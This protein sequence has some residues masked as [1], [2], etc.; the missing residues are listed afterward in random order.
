MTRYTFSGI[1]AVIGLLKQYPTLA[2]LSSFN[3]I[4]EVERKVKDAVR[5]SGCGC[6]AAPIY[7]A[8][9]HVYQS[10]LNNMQYGDHLMIKNAL[11]VEQLCYY[12]TDKD[13]KNVLKCI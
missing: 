13:G 2:S 7:A 6:S 11:K 1:S 10:A 12:I 4:M 9:K 8:N 3:G 5:K